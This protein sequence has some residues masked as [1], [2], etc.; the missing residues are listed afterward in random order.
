M[1]KEHRR[2][3]DRL[4]D[5]G[6]GVQGNAIED[7]TCLPGT[8]LDILERIDN[9]VR[10]PSA[11]KRTL[12]VCG[13]AG[14][15]KSTIASTVAHAWRF[16]ASCAVFHFRRGQDALNNRLVCAL[17]R[18]LGSSLVPEVRNAVLQSV[19]ENED[20]ANQRLNEQFKILLVASLRK[21]E[22]HSY[23]ILIIVDALDECDNAKDV[24]DFVTLI[25]QHSSSFPSQVRFLLTSRPETALHRARES[26][27]WSA[28]DLDSAPEVSEDLA[29]FIH[30]A[31][32]K[33]RDG[34][35]LPEGWPSA[36]DLARLVDMS[37]GLFQWARTAIT[38]ISDGSPVNRLRG[39][40]QR[41]AM[42]SGL[43]DLYHQILSKAMDNARKEPQ[44]QEL[45]RSVLGTLVVAPHPVSLEVVAT[46]YRDSEIFEGM[47]QE[48][49]IQFLREDVLMDLYSLLHIPTSAAEPMRFMHTSIRDLLVSEERCQDQ[50]YH[51]DT[52]QYHQ[53]LANLSLSVM[54][55]FLK[56]N[57]CKLSDLSEG[58]SEIQDIAELR[59][60]RVLRYC[61]QAWSIHLTEGV[62][63]SGLDKDVAR[64][65][66]AA[67]E[68]F[69]KERILG[70]IEVMSVIG[71][72][73]EAIRMAKHVHRW[74]LVKIFEVLLL[75]NLWNDVHRFITAFLEPISFGPLHI[76]AS[77]LPHCPSKT[78]LW[79]LYSS[80]ARV[81]LLGSRR[82]STW[83]Q[84]GETLST[85][86]RP[87]SAVCISPDGRLLA[88]ALSDHTIQLW[89][90]QTG[91]EFGEPLTGHSAI[92]SCVCFS[93]DG[94]LLASG[95]SWDMTIQLWD[96]QTGRQLGKLLTGNYYAESICIS[97][98][99]RLIAS[100]SNNAVIRLWDTQTRRQLGEPLT[101]HSNYVWSVCFS[102]NGRVLASGSKDSTIRLWDT[103]TGRQLGE[104]LTGHSGRVDS[105]CFSPDGKVLAST[106]QDKTIRLWDT[107]TGRQLGEPLTSQASFVKSLCFSPD[108]RLL[109]SASLGNAIGLW[110][111]RTGRL[112]GEP[113]TSYSI[114]M[115]S[116]C[117]SPNDKVL[118]FG[119][120]DNSI[121][122]WDTQTGRQLGEPLTGHSHRVRSVCFSPN[123][124]VLA[125]GSQDNTIRLWDTQTGMQLGEP[126]TGH[127]G[128]VRSV[129]FSRDGRVLA[130]TSWDETARLWDPQTGRQLGE[131]LTNNCNFGAFSPDPRLLATTFKDNTIRL[132]DTQT[133]TQLGQPLTG[134]SDS[135]W[136]VRFSPDGRVLAS[137][138]RDRTIRL[139]DTQTGK[140][141]G[142]PLT[143]FGP[144]LENF[145]FSPDGR[146]L[147]SKHWGGTI[148]LW[149]T[150]TGK[151]LG[152]PLTSHNRCFVSIDFSLD[153]MFLVGRDL[154]GYC[155]IWDIR[156][157][158]KCHPSPRIP[159]Q[160]A[161]GFQNNW[162]THSSY[163]LLWLPQEY[164]SYLNSSI[165]LHEKTLVFGEEGHTY[166]F[167]LS[168]L[169]RSLDGILYFEVSS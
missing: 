20:I 116:A 51:I 27:G 13:M 29:L 121:R 62:R 154:T 68:L 162:I 71:A 91:R 23:P 102:P 108:G 168:R 81:R 39:L 132:W 59:V 113:L 131:P 10:Y 34:Y 42:S 147:A 88:S 69:S 33:I 5:A 82:I 98:G 53:Q 16:R 138:S 136:P 72:T 47:E 145:C 67:F 66:L 25:H 7:V 6:Y 153:G 55:R 60:P 156:T 19:R 73:S 119:P 45:L 92:V 65:R 31:C 21:L 134:H 143:S 77:A 135:I 160:I 165:R 52:I 124:R 109:L 37:Q 110:D 93:P 15:G 142:K 24:V 90:T 148:R 85:Y 87:A 167:D 83:P 61:C 1:Q 64:R 125:S 17:A 22:G 120:D 103:E 44:K 150:Q 101:G 151:Q 41:Q 11:M 144:A 70:W 158:K 140:Q 146:R 84:V 133:R 32:T 139:W 137:G 126:L 43:D 74:L 129:S 18:Q 30:R 157:L 114:Q 118:A 100:K 3:L 112:L 155:N 117:A 99:G 76:Y 169:S 152:E 127:S 80:S 97:P 161:M 106:S 36:E 115:S 89:E 107:H 14:R 46:L 75:V 2:L 4:G 164:S 128:S 12:W 54:L 35:R 56:E 58:I 79:R 26:N 50:A 159:G 49:I 149:D 96:T 141:L 78:E 48:D 94:R 86:I 111:T 163:R 9:W 63:W 57:I 104:P 38:Y 122:L 40:L 28:V 105:V 8:R 166:I 130:S 95:G 123:G